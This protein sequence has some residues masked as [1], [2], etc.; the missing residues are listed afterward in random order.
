MLPKVHACMYFYIYTR[1]LLARETSEYTRSEG[2]LDARY[3]IAIFIA[4]IMEFRSGKVISTLYATLWWLFKLFL[5]V[6]S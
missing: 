2:A 4:G 5:E 1:V 3:F 6:V